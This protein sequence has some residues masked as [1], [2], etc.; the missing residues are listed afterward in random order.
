MDRM[1]QTAACCMLCAI[2]LAAFSEVAPGVTGSR[3][4]AIEG[5]V[6]AL[7]LEDLPPEDWKEPSKP[8]IT[9]RLK[10]GVDYWFTKG[11]GSWEI[12]AFEFIDVAVLAGIA[13]ELEWEDI[14]SDIP[15]F[16]VDLALLHNVRIS[17]RYGSGD[18]DDGELTDSDFLSVSTPFES[19]GN[20]KFSESKSDTD[21]DTEFYDINV[22]Y[23]LPEKWYPKLLSHAEV[24]LGYEYYSDELHMMNGVQTVSDG[25]FAPPVGPFGGLDSTYD[26]EWE[27]VRLGARAEYNPHPKVS[28]GVTLAVLAVLDYSGEGFWN[29]RREFR[30]QAPNYEH[31]A[32]SGEG[33]DVSVDLEYFPWE[34]V[35]IRVGYWYKQWSASDG[36]DTKFF[37]DA[38]AAELGLDGT[39]TT[40]DLGDVE[41]VR[42]GFFAG[43]V[44]KI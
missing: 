35:G 44:G 27:G 8:S 41:S 36:E 43:I 42:H 17:G 3:G 7:T 14:D 32:D 18:I 26:F 23:E 25:F 9:E 21:G 39:S 6:A 33:L 13:S 12:E 24:F 1:S 34:N 2:P 19:T 16:S 10:L 20:I 37:T 28:V 5:S 40:A 29:L 15:V 30:R 11:E 4:E 22:H 31:E 38:A